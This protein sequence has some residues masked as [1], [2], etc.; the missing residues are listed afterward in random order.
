M[1][2]WGE[3]TRLVHAGAARSPFGETSEALFLTSGFVYERAEVAEARFADRAPGYTYS[4]L[5]N[6][7][8]R[9]FEERMAAL[10]GS[11]EATATAS[12]M[13]AVFAVLMASLKAGDRVVAGRL[14]FGSTDYILRELLPRFGIRVTLV[15]PADP[16][17]WRRALDRPAQLVFFETPTNPT[18]ELVDIEA[19]SRIAKEAGALVVV[20]NVL[21]TPILQRPAELGADVVVYSATKHIDG[22]GRCLGGVILSS[23]A[24]RKDVLVPFLKHTGPAL[25]PFNAWVLLKG[26]ETLALRVRAQS[27][28]ALEIA[29]HLAGH[30]RIEAVRYPGLA[31]HPQHALAERQMRAA[32]PILAFRVGGGRARAF[33]VLN[34][35]RLIRISNNLGDVKSLATHPASTTHARLPQEERERLGIAEDLIRLSVGLEETEDL[36][37]DL[38]E[39]LEA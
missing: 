24:F 30:P 3:R 8:V 10:E 9:M 31:D 32:G 26:L 39:A 21:A 37:A 28:S 20:D 6:P 34:R 33:A 2:R 22:Q 17:A 7:T 14:L 19:V 25:S 4:R 5:A 23:A 12:G 35:L 1:D 38:E 36:I 27:E 15:D 13:A 18:L 29:R 11:E 16:E